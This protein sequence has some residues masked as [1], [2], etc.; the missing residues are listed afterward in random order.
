MIGKNVKNDGIRD[1]IEYIEKE[2]DK[3]ITTDSLCK[4]FGY[5]KEHFCRKFKKSTGLSPVT[6]LKIYRLE[7]AFSLIKNSD[8]SI[9]GIAAQCGFSD[10]NYF[11]RCF[12]A[13]YGNPPSYYRN[14]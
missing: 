3:D 10:S 2:F 5:S 6:Y 11:T 4:K 13:H 9:C 14:K 1:I 7:K 12:H 8:D